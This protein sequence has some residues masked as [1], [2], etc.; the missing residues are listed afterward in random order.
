M[1]HRL[2]ITL[3]NSLR[4]TALNLDANSVYRS[5]NRSCVKIMPNV[6]LAETAAFSLRSIPKIILVFVLA[7]VARC[8]ASFPL[9]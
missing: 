5:I 3:Y 8:V 6:V 4:V 1:G 9:N 7:H 2:G